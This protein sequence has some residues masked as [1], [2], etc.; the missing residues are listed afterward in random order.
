M[1]IQSHHEVVTAALGRRSVLLLAAALALPGRSLASS[2]SGPMKWVV[3]FPAG[4]AIDGL[5]R[6]VAQELGPRLSAAIVVENRPGAG[7]NIGVEQVVRQPPDGATALLA[8]FGLATNPSLFPKLPFDAQRDLAPVSLLGTSPMF[9]VAGPS[10]TDI[11]SFQDLMVRGKARGEKLVFG[12]AGAGTSTHLA[13]ELLESATG[14]EIQSVPYK[15]SAPA[16]TDLLGGHVG[17]VIDSPTVLLPH[18]R[19]GRVRALG[20]TSRTRTALLPTVPTISELGVAD[21]EVSPWYG[22][23]MRSG[24]PPERIAQLQAGIAS[25]ASSAHL[26]DKLLQLGIELK[27]STSTELE[28]H[29]A[30]E[31]KR[32]A[33]LI[34]NRGI[35]LE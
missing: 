25:V 5:A 22:V 34:R 21:Y 12:H 2:V 13:V 19:T 9:L 16:V 4:G 7:G 18:I 33:G 27:S 8:G 14:I 23:F 35:K 20:V 3:P 11:R 6:Q 29:L 1:N 32:W 15:G 17:Y 28:Q 31:T 10:Q 30:A 24:V 26:R